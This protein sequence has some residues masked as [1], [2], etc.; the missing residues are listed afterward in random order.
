[1]LSNNDVSLVTEEKSEP[2]VHID[3]VL[4]ISKYRTTKNEIS[5][6]HF[7]SNSRWNAMNVFILAHRSWRWHHAGHDDCLLF[8]HIAAVFRAIAMN[9]QAQ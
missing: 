3:V 1:M 7:H 6:K 2:N 8:L 5:S 9:L 4:L